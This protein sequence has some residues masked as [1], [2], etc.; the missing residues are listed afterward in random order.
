MGGREEE[1]KE[2]EWK[3]EWKDEEVV[4]M[5]VVAMV[6]V[7]QVAVTEAAMAAAETVEEKEAHPLTHQHSSVHQSAHS[8][9]GTR[10]AG[11]CC[12]MQPRVDYPLA[13]EHTPP[14]SR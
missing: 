10:R 4:A 7:V 9:H 5:V 1:W 3:E 6:V 8:P 14:M 11:R 13:H 12:P 2:E